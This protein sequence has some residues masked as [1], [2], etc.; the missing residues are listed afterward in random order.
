[1]DGGH[2]AAAEQ[3]RSISLGRPC[4]STV[5]GPRRTR[6]RR[7]S[8]LTSTTVAS[9][10]RARIFVQIGDENVHRVRVLMDE[11]FGDTNFVSQIPFKTTSGP[12]VSRAAPTCSP[13]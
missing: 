11:I 3:A 1:V 4:T 13:R 7:P 5:P 6:R 12:A 10:R 8:S 2:L 9:T